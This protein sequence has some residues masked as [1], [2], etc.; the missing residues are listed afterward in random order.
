MSNLKLPPVGLPANGL[1]IGIPHGRPGK[2]PIWLPVGYFV[3]HPQYGRGKLTLNF[4]D[5]NYSI[6]PAEVE[7]VLQA[8][9]DVVEAAVIPVPHPELGEEVAAFV[10][11]RPGAA[12][13]PDDLIAYMTPHMSGQD[14]SFSTSTDPILAYLD[15]NPVWGVADES[16]FTETDP[17]E[18]DLST[19]FLKDPDAWMAMRSRLREQKSIES[20]RGLVATGQRQARAAFVLG[21][22]AAT[23][24]LTRAR[25]IGAVEAPGVRAVSIEEVLDGDF[26]PRSGEAFVPARGDDLAY[27]IYTSG[28]TGRPKGAMLTHRALLTMVQQFLAL[29]PPR[30]PDAGTIVGMARERGLFVRDVGNMGCAL[31]THA[32]RLAV[33]GRVTK[34][35]DF[36]ALNRA[37]RSRTWAMISSSVSVRE[38]YSRLQP[39]G[40]SSQK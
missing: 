33:K 18:K 37:S 7:T 28:T 29:V 27:L 11:L 26:G 9:P 24:L 13:G 39:T 12:A 38:P 23:L 20:L 32:V 10:A 16:A 40:K 3:L 22:A 35:T 17:I 4:I 8:H 34:V 14:I 36:G 15:A 5:E 1:G 25:W 6:F 19:C 21:D 30:G 2:K 31:G